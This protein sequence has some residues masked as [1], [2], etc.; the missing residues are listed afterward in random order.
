MKRPPAKRN[1]AGCVQSWRRS[2]T[3]KSRL[4]G[5]SPRRGIGAFRAVWSPGQCREVNSTS[6][7]ATLCCCKTT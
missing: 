2:F 5:V 7:P 6:A 1:T 4:L 3:G